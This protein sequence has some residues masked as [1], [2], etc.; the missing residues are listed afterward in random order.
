VKEINQV[1]E[2]NVDGMKI[3]EWTSEELDVIV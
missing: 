2:M 1:G 3:L